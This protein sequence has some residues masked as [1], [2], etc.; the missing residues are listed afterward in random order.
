M[1][2]W[3]K[4]NTFKIIIIIVVIIIIFVINSY[5]QMTKPVPK[6][7]IQ[8]ENEITV[9]SLVA[10]L[11]DHEPF[12][13]A[14]GRV[15]TQRIGNL[16]FGV[17]GTISYLSDK[18]VNG[19][20]VKKGE[21]LGKLDEEKFLLIVQRLQADIKE[22]TKQ[23]ELRKKQLDRNKIMLEKKVISPSVY[24]EELIKYS[25]SQ[26]MLNNSKINLGLAKKD[27]KDAT[28]IAKSN[29]I[30]SN[31]NAHEGLLVSSNSMLGTFRSLDHVEIE[32]IVPARIFSISEKLI[33]KK[34]E[35]LW[36]TGSEK[37]IKKNAI[38]TRFQGIIND[39]SGG[40]KIFA[41]FNDNT[42][43]ELIPLDSFVKIIYPLERFVSVIKIPETALFNKQ[44]IFVIK[45]GRAK[46]VQVNVLHSN[47][48]YYLLK[49]D[50]LGGVDIILNRF[51]SN[52]E[53]T[54]IKL[55]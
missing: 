28:L 45:N 2:Y 15:K 4:K 33:G 9:N 49:N 22:L 32:F 3:L 19:G 51:S 7:K 12:L 53:G 40:G 24:D 6:V 13:S 8:K 20:K 11:E 30:I 41:K 21:I 1:F 55:N 29:G 23:I 50:N 17:S 42:T 52:I 34:I 5:L 10:K 43:D 35:V 38:I 27:L 18:F 47:T 26:Q 16:S 37:V 39:D 44:Y 36:E 48:G 25:K 54:K 31:V 46:K 14:F